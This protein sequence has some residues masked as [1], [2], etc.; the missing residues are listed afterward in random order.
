[1][2]VLLMAISYRVM[3]KDS[4]E[5]YVNLFQLQ[6]IINRLMGVEKIKLIVKA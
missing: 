5:T 3:A 2:P 4:R 6:R 1:M